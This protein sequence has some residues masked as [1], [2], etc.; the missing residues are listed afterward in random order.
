MS[1][2]LWALSFVLFLLFLGANAQELSSTNAPIVLKAR[3]CEVIVVIEWNRHDPKFPKAAEF[4]RVF[5]A[6]RGSGLYAHYTE[7]AAARAD[8]I[9]KVDDDALSDLVTLTVHNPEDNSP[10]YYESRERI[11][12]DNDVKRL[13]SHFLTAVATARNAEAIE[14]AAAQTQIAEQEATRK[15]AELLPIE[16]E[17]AC[18]TSDTNCKPT[19]E[20]YKVWIVG[21]S[22]FESRPSHVIAPNLNVGTECSARRNGKEWQGSCVY[23]AT[24]SK[25]SDNGS[26]GREIVAVCKVETSEHVVEVNALRVS[27]V[28]QSIDWTPLKDRK[29]PVAGSNYKEFAVTPKD[30]PLDEDIAACIKTGVCKEK[31]QQ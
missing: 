30:Q 26:S 1:R 3:K 21:D 29:C 23:T 7:T 17:I 11:D 31:A 25:P 13:I 8:I 12:L 4:S 16:W 2:A 18:P 22:I 24:W 20:P 14:R 10:L 15:L 5:Q 6:V 28:S 27:G 9:L 19:G